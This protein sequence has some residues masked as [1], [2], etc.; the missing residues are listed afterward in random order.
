MKLCQHCQCPK[1]GNPCDCDMMP[2]KR[3]ASCPSDATDCSRLDYERATV[4]RL[5]E[6]RGEFVT[7][8]DGFIYWWPSAKTEHAGH[9]SPYQLRILADELDRRNAAWQAVID[10]EFSSEN[11]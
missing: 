8:V 11:A 3:T 1:N 7:D 9:L 5:A 6:E 4:C 2:S 10:A